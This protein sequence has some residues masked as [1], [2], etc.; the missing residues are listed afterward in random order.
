MSSRFP[1][2]AFPC[3]GGVVRLPDEVFDLPG[4]IVSLEDNVCPDVFRFPRAAGQPWRNAT[5]SAA[6]FTA[7]LPASLQ[8]VGPPGGEEQLIALGRLIEA[9]VTP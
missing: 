9:V 1:G 6:S 3:A 7:R 5:S 8:L 4:G 2:D